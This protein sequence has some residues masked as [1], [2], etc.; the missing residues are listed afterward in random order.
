MKIASTSTKNSPEARFCKSFLRNGD[1]V[2]GITASITDQVVSFRTKGWPDFLVKRGNKLIFYEVKGKKE[3][4]TS[5]N[6]I[7]ILRAL[8]HANRATLEAYVAIEDAKA[9]RGFRLEDPDH[10]K[11]RLR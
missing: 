5:R 8:K 10:Y 7:E 9:P 1:K 11:A 4:D 2:L 3:K 6:Q